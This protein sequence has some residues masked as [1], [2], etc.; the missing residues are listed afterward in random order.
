M[1]PIKLSSLA[2]LAVVFATIQ[3]TQAKRKRERAKMPSFKDILNVA[4]DTLLEDLPEQIEKS[5]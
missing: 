2:W 5:S 1:R 4:V 3:S